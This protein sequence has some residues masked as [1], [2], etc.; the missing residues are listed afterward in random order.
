MCFADWRENRP[1]VTSESGL[2]DGG[3]NWFRP[4]N[5]FL[6]VCL[7]SSTGALVLLTRFLVW[8]ERLRSSRRFLLFVLCWSDRASVSIC[9]CGRQDIRINLL[10]DTAVN[11]DGLRRVPCNGY[12][13]WVSSPLSSFSSDRLSLPALRFLSRLC[14]GFRFRLSFASKPEMFGRGGRFF[15]RFCFCR[16]LPLL[17]GFLC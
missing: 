4:P 12:R 17:G 13:S 10:L 6:F 3:S 8:L 5:C 16:L 11:G 2:L 1:L 15:A 9:G 7:F 14:F